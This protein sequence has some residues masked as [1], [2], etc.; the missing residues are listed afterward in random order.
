MI[1]PTQPDD[2]PHLV[3]MTQATG[4][5]RPIEIEALREVLDDYYAEE[6]QRGHR[7]VCYEKDG[8]VLGFAY[9]APTP[10]TDRTWHLYWIVVGKDI[11]A[12]GLGT[13]LLRHV[14][15]DI[16]AQNGRVLFI[17]TGSVPHYEK[18]RQFYVKN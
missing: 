7:C 5:F 10:M 3:A 14:E 13:K 17:E 9:H 11:Q 8:K 4:M 18:T 16:K 6:Q 1:R 15:E 2:T 12:R